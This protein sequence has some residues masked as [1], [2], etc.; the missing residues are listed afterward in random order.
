MY[1]TQQTTIDEINRIIEE[2][3]VN[4]PTATIVPVKAL[5]PSFIQAG[6]FTKDR[7]NGAPIRS[8]LKELD[9][10]NR[11]DQIP[12]VHPERHEDATY[13]YFIPK[14]APTPTTNYKEEKKKDNK[15]PASYK[16]SDK[17]YVI[18]L[19]DKVIGMKSDRKKRFDFLLGDLHKDG[20][21]QTKLP[22]DAY[23]A[24][25]Q[26]VV[27][28]NDI[29]PWEQAIPVINNEEDDLIDDD[30]EENEFEE[31]TPKAKRVISREEQ[32]SIYN[33]RR[34]KV[35]PKHDIDFVLISYSDFNHD[36]SLKIIRDE[37]YDSKIVYKALEEFISSQE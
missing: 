27:H 8:I 29:K 37:A 36:A 21:S 25:L 20:V 14:Q 16:N 11:L 7:K 32:R 19:C 26:L 24:M 33:E 31:S 23:Y 18:D 3:F 2:Y 17:K 1:S 6:I 10:S 15:I 34:A 35:F 28:Y 13:W 9:S 30:I 12:T 22:V 5:M 4:N